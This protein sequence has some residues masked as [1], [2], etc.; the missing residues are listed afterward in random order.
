MNYFTHNI[1]IKTQD[2]EKIKEILANKFDFILEDSNERG[3]LQASIHHRGMMNM[4]KVLETIN[5]FEY[6][7]ILNIHDVPY[8]SFMGDY[9]VVNGEMTY[10]KTYDDMEEFMK[11]VLKQSDEDINKLVNDLKG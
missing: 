5:T 6:E 3:V 2:T 4:D 11:V 7:M 10:R 9:K 8:C 1:Q